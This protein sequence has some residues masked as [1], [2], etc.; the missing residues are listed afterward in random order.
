M[1][2]VKLRTDGLQEGRGGLLGL[3]GTCST[4]RTSLFP[5]PRCRT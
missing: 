2:A 3:T 5:F 1:A 4:S